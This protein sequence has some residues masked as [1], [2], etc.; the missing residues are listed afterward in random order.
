MCK[1]ACDYVCVYVGMH[2]FLCMYAC[3][4]CMYYDNNNNRMF[5]SVNYAFVVFWL[6]TNKINI[7]KRDYDPEHFRLTN[8]NSDPETDAMIA[9]T[10][11]MA[12]TSADQLSVLRFC[13]DKTWL[14]QLMVAGCLV[15]LL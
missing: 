3:E 14:P 2:V 4:P 6:R 11:T 13:L 7:N 15:S 8:E 9:E 1:S 12:K 5:L 10:G